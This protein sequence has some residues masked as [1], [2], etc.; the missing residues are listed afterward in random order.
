MIFEILVLGSGDACSFGGKNQTSFFIKTDKKTFLLD[1]GP[2][3]LSE[4]RRRNINTD[5][6]DFILNTHMH[7]DHYG[8]IPYL[9][10]DLN[11]NYKIESFLVIGAEGIAER[12]NIL[13]DLLYPGYGFEKFKF[14][15]IFEEL[16]PYQEI[17]VDDIKIKSYPMLHSAY[18]YCFGYKI[19]YKNK[20]FAYTGDTGWTNEIIN[21]SNNTD[22]FIIE[23]S[24]YNKD[25][26]NS[27][28]SY[29]ELL[30]NI[31]KINTKNILLTH[32]SK[33][34]YDNIDKI[35]H[36]IAYD[37]MKIFI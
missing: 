6:I 16:K 8:G 14:K 19:E 9:L 30:E 22:L 33:D 26:R 24:Y 20:S 5:K 10:L 36:A 13:Q 2:S 15:M 29:K 21:L 25:I 28:V 4:L 35:S 31:N 17:N 34:A 18:S 7:G 1:C 12:L 32:L 37:G 11:I 3:T 27:H 23:C